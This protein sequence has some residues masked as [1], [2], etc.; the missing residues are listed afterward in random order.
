M[1]YICIIEFKYFSFK[2]KRKRTKGR[3]CYNCIKYVL[4][5]FII[6]APGFFQYNYSI[7]CHKGY[8]QKVK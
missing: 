8:S 6:K 4:Q 3:K 1:N 5:H 7:Q 2:F